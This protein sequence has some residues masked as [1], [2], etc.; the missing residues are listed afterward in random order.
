MLRPIEREV[1]QYIVFAVNT[2]HGKGKLRGY[3]LRV[4]P[5]GKLEVRVAERGYYE[6]SADEILN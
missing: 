1:G 4:L 2:L 5:N 3:V 6:V